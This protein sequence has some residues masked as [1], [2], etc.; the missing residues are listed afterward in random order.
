L[1]PDPHD[2]NNWDKIVRIIATVLTSAGTQYRNGPASIA[3]ATVGG[4]IV[5]VVYIIVDGILRITDAWVR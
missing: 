1:V 5:E 3:S 2:P 4:Q